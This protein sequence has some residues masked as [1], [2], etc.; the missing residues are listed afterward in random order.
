EEGGP[1]SVESYGQKNEVLVISQTQAAHEQV[2]DLLSQL[3]EIH[4][5][6]QDE[7]TAANSPD[8]AKEPEALVLRVYE[9][10]MS[11]PNAPG[12]TPQ[13]VAEVVKALVAPKSWNQQDVYVRGVTGKLLVRQAPSVHKEIR[14][15]LGNLGAGVAAPPAGPGVRGGQPTTGQGLGGTGGGI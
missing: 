15:L 4:R 11:A 9:L 6:Q 14:K 8:K 12:M 1:G 10:R 2:A 7:A 13:E 5:K 3:R